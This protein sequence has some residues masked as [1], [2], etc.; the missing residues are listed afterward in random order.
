MDW[1]WWQR[2]IVYQVYPRSFQDSDGDGTGDLRGIAARLDHLA[3][4]GVDAV[5][6]SPIFPSPMTDFGYDVSDYC[7]IDPL[8]GSMADFDALLER[9][10]A[11]GLKLILD[12]VPNHSSD[13]HP[14]F[15]ASRNRT[16]DKA[17]WY[18]W[19]DPAPDGGPPNNW[20]AHFGG[21]AWTFDKARAQYYYHSFLPTQPDL[22][23]RN[24]EV[25]GAMYDVL[26]FWLERGVDGF[27]VDV[28][29]MMI[30]DAQFRD[31]PP[32]PAWRPGQRLHDSLL[33]LYTQDRPEVH[34]IVAEMR[35]VLDEFDDRVLIGEIY[36]PIDKLVAYYGLG[37]R[38]AHLPFNFHL[39]LL[40]DWSAKG[41]AGLITRYEAALP[42]NAWPNWVLG[43]HDRPRVATRLGPAQA[44]VAAMLLLTLRGTPTLYMGDE[45]G[46]QDTPIPP[47]AIRD[48]A[49]LRQPG[50][51]Q[52]RD[53][54]RT[55]FP[56]DD[57]PGRGFTTG[58]P[59]LPIGTDASLAEQRD[60]PASILS[61]HRRLIA[62]RRA[63]QALSIG[64]IS[65]VAAHG[66]VLTYSRMLNGVRFDV[67]L[68]TSAAPAEVS[69]AGG[70]VVADTTRADPYAI[71][72]GPFSLSPNQGVLIRC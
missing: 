49:E 23:W 17:D 64:G 68:N 40:Q 4:L 10:H 62:L 22:N 35:G 27:R 14:W 69:L 26:R 44:R 33:P 48:P 52:G 2:G 43:N 41:L 63:H 38:G 12:F 31:N 3:W 61:L 58:T 71:G 36:L 56:W 5:W 55:P 30:K 46:M 54:V 65:D 18:I 19:R 1:A 24:P 45:L 21:R 16:G 53:P 29:W 47:G 37:G 59:W 34:A 6:L 8:F 32:N 42:E 9:A 70:A 15:Q 20:L 28:I 25:R 60:D 72:R 66:A 39:L 57:S 11:L 7:G 51:G 67:A 13:Q 50:Q